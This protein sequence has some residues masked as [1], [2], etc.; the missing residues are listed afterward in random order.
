MMKKIRLLLTVIIAFGCQNKQDTESILVDRVWISH[1]NTQY[2]FSSKYKKQFK[3]VSQNSSGELKP[4][5]G[6]PSTQKFNPN[7]EGWLSLGRFKVEGD[8]LYV[9]RNSDIDGEKVRSMYLKP[10]KDSVIGIITHKT[11]TAYNPDG[12]KWVSKET[13]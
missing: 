11:M 13:N 8:T 10:G 12:R 1:N 2:Y 6:T 7:L 3:W 9:Q 4:A 5:Y